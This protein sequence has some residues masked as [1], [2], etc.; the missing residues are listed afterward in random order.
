MIHRRGVPPWSRKTAIATL[1]LALA[2]FTWPSAALGDPATA[3]ALFRDGRR[4]LDEGHYDE[5]CSK[6]AESQAQDPASGTL[7]N[8]ALCY[9]KQGK[10]ATAW[11]HYRSAAVLARKDGRTD[12]VAIA[13]QKNA[14]LEGRVPHLILRAARPRPGIEARWGNVRMGAG[15]FD[16]PIPVD[17]GTYEVTV[18]APGFR[19]FSVTV[20][21]AEK[22]SKTVEVPDL[23]PEAVPSPDEPRVSLAPPPKASDA[24]TVRTDNERHNGSRLPGL[25]VGG[26]GLVGLGIGTFFGVSSLRAYAD[27]E[28]ECPSHSGCTDAVKDVRRDAETKAWV[29][30]ISLGAGL[31]AVGA[32]AWLVF[33]STDGGKEAVFVNISPVANGAEVSARASF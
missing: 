31:L 17:P 6:L 15:A 8:L 12:R 1:S 25:I 26:V 11:A 29:A 5:A 23:E 9:E 20:S 4:L 2:I 30:N 21:V 13:E 16:T 14:E 32:G 24:P 10:L 33:G 28:R 18:S 7:I 3:E 27:A 19:D 22:E